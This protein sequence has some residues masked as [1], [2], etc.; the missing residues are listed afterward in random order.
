MQQ[1]KVEVNAIQKVQLKLGLMFV[2]VVIALLAFMIAMD[3]KNTGDID[4]TMDML[5]I[6]LAVLLPTFVTGLVIGI[7]RQKKILN[8][9]VLTF[10]GNLITRE[11]LHTP[12]ISIYTN[13]VQKIVKG[14]K[15]GYA[16]YGNNPQDIILIPKWIQNSS[17]LEDTLRS[18][19]A[20]T[21]QPKQSI[22]HKYPML[23]GI[24]NLVAMGCLYIATNKII[25]VLA[26]VFLTATLIWSYKE[27]RASKNVDDKTNR[28]TSLFLPFLILI[29]VL[30]VIL[31]LLGIDQ[32]N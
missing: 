22:I 32:V 30:R 4:E 10:S 28:I 21:P 26:G 25:V 16:V 1:Y 29:V 5:P 19:S 12:T 18:I 20:I 15:G 17:E 8:S 27:I 9:Y 31:L 3:Y 23:L 11:Q 13:E 2:P 14:D 7:K 6:Y 24:L